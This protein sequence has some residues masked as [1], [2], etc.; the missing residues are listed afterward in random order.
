MEL[1]LY[2][3]L[4]TCVSLS[5]M[6]RRIRERTVI[7]KIKKKDLILSQGVELTPPN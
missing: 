2:R 1:A 3:F 4:E 7:A 6:Q 5:D